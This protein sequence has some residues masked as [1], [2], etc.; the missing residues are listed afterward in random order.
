[1]VVVVRG[2]KGKDS[3]GVKEERGER[4]GRKEGCLT[5]VMIA[6]R[7]KLVPPAKSVSLSN[8]RENAI[9]KKKS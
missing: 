9:E 2:V 7:T 8:L 6:R 1:M 4:G 5:Y 3:D